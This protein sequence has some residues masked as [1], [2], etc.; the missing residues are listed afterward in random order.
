MTA[1]AA[2]Q[3]PVSRNRAGHRRPGSLLSPFMRHSLILVGAGVV[4]YLLA[5]YLP[6]EGQPEGWIGAGLLLGVVSGLLA[7]AW[8]GALFLLVGAVTGVLVEMHVRLGASPETA[9]E[10]AVSGPLLLTAL[11]AAALAFLVT[12]VVLRLVRRH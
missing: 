8:L 7:G 11:G 1:S 3:P 12:I 10:L 5:V 4:G 2:T 6:V 9:A